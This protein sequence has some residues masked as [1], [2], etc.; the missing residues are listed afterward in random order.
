MQLAK[1]VEVRYVGAAV[2]AASS[3]DS[4]S[5]IVDMAGWD[6]VIFVTTVTASTATSVVTLKVEQNTA[7]SDT[8]MSA[9]SG[10]SAAATSA[11]T[12]DLNGKTLIVSV[13]QPRERYVQAVRTSATA[14]S[15]FGQ[16]IAIL[17]GPRTAPTAAASTTAA[18]AD[19]VSPAEA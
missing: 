2:A 15:A 3:T 13:H 7:N 14:N 4:N 8:G 10:A 6:G 16:V 5:T 9:L 11:V 17:Y 1:N 18:S 19:T 12:D